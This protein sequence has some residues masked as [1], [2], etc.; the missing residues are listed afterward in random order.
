[1]G[2]ILL[3]VSFILGSVLLPFGFLWFVFKSWYKQT[4]KGGVSRISDQSR[5]CAVSIDRTFNVLCE[6]LFNDILITK[7][8]YKFGNGK[9][10]ISSVVGKNK[11]KDTLSYMG[12]ILD[13]ILDWLDENHS[14]KSIEVLNMNKTNVNINDIN[15]NGVN[16]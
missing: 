13:S 14:I 9:E 12:K 1:M 3:L 16:N 8:G 2:V 11:V 10:T 6:D 5:D 4:F 15:S 7:E